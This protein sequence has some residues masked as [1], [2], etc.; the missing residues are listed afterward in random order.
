MNLNVEENLKSLE[1]WLS[2]IGLLTVMWTPVERKIDECAFILYSSKNKGKR[3]HNLNHKL[4]YIKNNLP[5]GVNCIPDFDEIIKITKGTSQVR[6]VCVHGVIDS[7]DDNKMVI[8]KVQGKSDNYQIEMFTYDQ[9]R[10]FSAGNNLSVLYEIWDK[11]C[12]DLNLTLS[13][14]RREHQ[15]HD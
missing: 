10:L 1:P 2:V 14:S 4:E 3:P 5:S 15:Y 13:T 9:R 12:K 7:Y 11:L 8:G 6:D